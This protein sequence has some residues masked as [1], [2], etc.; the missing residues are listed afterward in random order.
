M[1]L[2]ISAT[3]RE[4][5]TEASSGARN[6]PSRFLYRRFVWAISESLRF[7]EKLSPRKEWKSRSSRRFHILSLS[8]TA[9]AVL[10]TLPPDMIFQ[11]YLLPTALAP[12]SSERVVN[13]SVELLRQLHA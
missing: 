13:K 7:R 9:M 12:D 8:A 4:P 2:G 3:G 1:W 11:A 10:L 5:F 6:P